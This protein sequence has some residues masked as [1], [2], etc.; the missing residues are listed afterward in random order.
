MGIPDYVPGPYRNRA[1][2]RLCVNPTFYEIPLQKAT[3]ENPVDVVTRARRSYTG[4]SFT[5]VDLRDKNR[6]SRTRD[7]AAESNVQRPHTPPNDSQ[8]VQTDSSCEVTDLRSLITGKQPPPKLVT[9]AQN[10]SW[11]GFKYIT[12]FITNIEFVHHIISTFIS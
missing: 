12:K 5:Q 11:K 4:Y 2:D 7:T 6:N 9:E 3:G 1:M 10:T 8:T